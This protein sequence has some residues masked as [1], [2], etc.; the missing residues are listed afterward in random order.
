MEITTSIIPLM[1]DDSIA[2]NVCRVLF[3]IINVNA[4]FTTARTISF[5]QLCPLNLGMPS[6]NKLLASIM[7]D[8]IPMLS[9][10]TAIGSN[11][12]L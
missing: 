6:H 11:L 3:H 4:V 1:I 8:P 9:I 12:P 7:V 10:V 2:V 5:N